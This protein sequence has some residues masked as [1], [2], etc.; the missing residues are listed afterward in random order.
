MNLFDR[1][2]LTLAKGIKASTNL[3]FMPEWYRYSIAPLA[4][5]A[6]I[7]QGYKKN[8]AVF[9]CV[10]ALA[11]GFPEPKLDVY[12]ELPD[13]STE[14]DLKN[15]RLRQLL[16]KP[17]RSMSQVE[18]M[19]FCVV[20][21]SLG[22][23]VLIWK[24][25]N[26]TGDVIGLWPFTVDVITAIPSTDTSKGLV[27]HYELNNGEG[28]PLTIQ[29]RDI[30]QWKWMVDPLRPWRGMGALEAAWQDVASDNEGT[31]YM[32]SLLKNNAVPPVV[33]TLVQG[34]EL[35]EP[36]AKRLKKQWM[37]RYGGANRGMPVFLEAGM[38]V[39]KMAMNLEEMAFEV[40]KNVPETRICAVFRVPP[41]IAGVNA[42]LKRS[43][44]GDKHARRGFV[45]DTL[46][47]LWRQFSA[48][49]ESG[50]HEDFYGDWIL[51]FDLS[52]VR[53]LQEDES[54]VWTRVTRAWQAGLIKRSTGKRILGI[55]V[56]A[57][58]EVYFTDFYALQD[59]NARANDG[60][61]A[62]SGKRKTKAR[63]ADVT[64]LMASLRAKRE[65]TTQSMIP[66]VEMFFSDLAEKIVARAENEK[67][68]R[69]E[70]GIT[71]EDLFEDEDWSELLEVN[72]RFILNLLRLSW[73]D[74]NTMLDSEMAFDQTDPAITQAL[75]NSGSQIKDIEQTTKEA[76]QDLLKHANE[77]DWSID[78]LV[79]GDETHKGLRDL[80][81]QTYEG[82]AE[83]IARWELGHAQNSTS[84]ERY[85]GSG[86]EK[87]MVLDNGF[88][89]SNE[90]CKWIDGQIR[91]LAWC[92][93]NHPG[94]G[95]SGI[96]NPLQH[97]RCVRAYAPYFDDEE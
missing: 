82:R 47:S 4:F 55:Q 53:A 72:K 3:T 91:S 76:V 75:N 23:E 37:Q 9:A 79:R 21:A 63:K 8:S 41:V 43:D 67:S 44:Y 38:T 93:S 69:K 26:E 51:Q 31:S 56:D 19:Q 81:E 20:Y 87:V 14:K 89:N 5:R 49:M 80:V 50:L 85:Q 65:S 45:E 73:G 39:Q 11:F 74:W 96:K 32:Y 33:I 97:P 15:K 10:T 46:A 62:E 52:K 84:L 90:N 78:Q 94:E 57:E 1:F 64:A 86:L 77:N 35:T 12:K 13:G 27:D 60:A 25:R 95:P 61:E 58:D 7:I 54:Q 71:V 40:L 42:G 2:R 59:P 36:K 28:A 48:E 66:V 92:E 29:P 83:N 34:D 17:N 88:D 6:L 70:I 68:Y 24:E 18:F 16:L 30:I 22:G